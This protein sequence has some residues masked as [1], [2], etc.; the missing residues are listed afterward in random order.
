MDSVILRV[1]RRRGLTDP[2]QIGQS[3]WVPD[4]SKNTP[5]ELTA[6]LIAP[7]EVNGPGELAASCDFPVL[8]P[9]YWPQGLGGST[10]ELLH[11]PIGSTYQVWRRHGGI[12]VGIHGSGYGK[13]ERVRYPNDLVPVPD[14]PFP[15]RAYVKGPFVQIVVQA[16]ATVVSVVAIGV[17]DA[18]TESL[19][20]ARSLGGVSPPSPLESV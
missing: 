1:T 9:T 7:I 17:S 18:L 3:G 11:T 5:V 13:S 15:T 8:V 20:V 10:Y 19:A 14:M 2:L 12:Y 4:A 6:A 16:S